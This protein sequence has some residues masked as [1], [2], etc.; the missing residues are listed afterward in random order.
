MKHPH[1]PI[2][3]P[4][5][6]RVT[7]VFAG[8]CVLAASLHGQSEPRQVV[9]D[10]AVAPGTGKRLWTAPL[11]RHQGIKVPAPEAE[12]PVSAEILAR[13]LPVHPGDSS[14]SAHRPFVGT[15]YR[16]AF[17]QGE[18]TPP[19]AERIDPR[20]MD[21]WRGHADGSA[22]TYGFVM[23]QGRITAAKQRRVEALGVTLHEIHTYQSFKAT[24]PFRAIPG[25]L[26]SRDVRWI[27]YA[28]PE[29]K[30]GPFL[31]QRLAA[32]PP[33][34]RI[35]LFVQVFGDDR[36]AAS[37][38][39]VE[40]P[41]SEDGRYGAVTAFLPHGPAQRAFEAL[42][43]RVLVYHPLERIF[44]LEIAAEHCE[45]LARMDLVHCLDLVTSAAVDNDHSAR[46]TGVDHTRELPESDGSS[47]VLG[48]IDSGVWVDHVDLPSQHFVAWNYSKETNTLPTQGTSWHGTFVAGIMLGRGLG[49]PQGRYKGAAPG[50]AGSA[51]TKLFI[52]KA[53]PPKKTAELD[54]A[55]ARMRGGHGTAPHPHIVNCSW[56]SGPGGF[57]TYPMNILVD[58]NA[59]TYGQCMVFSAGNDGGVF[60]D[61]AHK[62]LNHPG[63]SKNAITVGCMTS[64]DISL[65]RA[66]NQKRPQRRS[67]ALPKNHEYAIP[68]ETSDASTPLRM[69]S[70]SFIFSAS[71]TTTVSVHLHAA[72]A[73][74]TAPM[75][76]PLAIAD[77]VLIPKD[78]GTREA[79]FDKPYL[80]SPGAKYFFVIKTGA[81]GT[82]YRWNASLQNTN[83]PA[84]LTIAERPVGGSW[85]NGLDTPIFFLRCSLRAGESAPNSSKGPTH[86]DRFKPDLVAPGVELRSCQDHTTD[87]Y[88]RG[89]TPA[90]SW[91]APHVSGI[92]AGLIDHYPALEYH[93]EGVRALLA[94]TANPHNGTA[95]TGNKGAHGY[96]FRQGMGLPDAHKAN[97]SRDTPQGWVTG[98]EL[99]DLDSSH[100]GA[101]FDVEVP[102]DAERMTTVLTFVEQGASG[103]AMRACLADLDLY[104]EH[105]KLTTRY[106][107]GQYS[108]Q[109]RWDTM[110]AYVNLQSISKLRGKKVRIKVH[111]RVRPAKGRKVRYAVAYCID[112]GGLKPQPSLTITA[113]PMLPGAKAELSG[114]ASLSEGVLTNAV[115]QVL[116][117]GGFEFSD[118][119]MNAQNGLR[120]DPESRVFPFGHLGYWYE[121]RSRRFSWKISKASRGLSRVKIQ[122]R[123]PF[124]QYTR[125]VNVCVDNLVPARPQGLRTLTHSTG[126]WSKNASVIFAWTAVSDQGC[127]GLEGLYYGITQGAPAHVAKGVRLTPSLTSRA[128]PFPSSAADQ[129]LNLFVVDRV[130]LRSPAASLGPFRIDAVAPLIQS[131]QL[132]DG[133]LRTRQ[134][135]LPLTIQRSDA[136]SGVAEY[137]YSMSNGSKWSAWTSIKQAPTVDLSAHGGSRGDGL[138][139][140]SVEVRDKAGNVSPTRRVSVVLDTSA[141]SVNSVSIAGGSATTASLSNPVDLQVSGAPSEYRW[142]MDGSTW[143]PWAD[144]VARF[145]ADLSKHGGSS[146]AG[147]KTVHVMVRDA[148]GNASQVATDSIDYR[149]TPSLKSLNRTKIGNIGAGVLVLTGTRL[150]GA[151]RVDFGKHALSAGTG[152]DWYQGYFKVRSDT[153]ID[154]YAPQALPPG[155]YGLQVHVGRTPSNS[156]ACTVTLVSSR[157]LSC[158]S[159]VD[160]KDKFRVLVA[161]GDQPVDSFSL[162]TASL[163]EVGVSIP[164]FVTLD[165]GGLKTG[166]FH[167]SFF[168]V[169][170]QVAHD[171]VTGVAEWIF[172]A[173]IQGVDVHFQAVVV[174]QARPG[175][176]PFKESS[177]RRIRIR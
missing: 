123:T 160:Y 126:S 120:V 121:S 56:H 114:I 140:C 157:R 22:Q 61:E 125:T 132:G 40:S 73:A 113:P 175:V 159:S 62:S 164:N 173:L 111:A 47:A 96:E 72:N 34:E 23:F 57:G 24:I 135:Q 14:L 5:G 91:A 17:V 165:H 59:Y 28:R 169:P 18:Y 58:S 83:V 76:A 162:L 42:G 63:D 115:V 19:A 45:T 112:R 35:P 6:R 99:N 51:A 106:D 4:V 11:T 107:V 127:A 29:Q 153:R 31:S 109:R 50:A 75:G 102:A 78:R 143:S 39:V 8:I 144:I 136:H 92:A 37:R 2:S 67:W 81:V 118:L 79:V 1:H 141:P 86:D 68:Y 119:V 54:R 105:D 26:A 161:R 177:A 168:L 155:K 98:Y 166:G 139:T 30:L 158:R 95:R 176:L 110:D 133:S 77:N 43:A 128:V 53:L 65:L 12:S 15:P 150:S 71:I 103:L 145:T 122:I 32:C 156:L 101:Y 52:C 84:V 46:A 44:K 130:G 108:S 25:L 16:L 88:A 148:A 134:L 48:I 13:P 138:K 82:V 137:R 154:V 97:G 49:N 85:S 70:V 94:A 152:K 64:T 171:K 174:D 142:S 124:G 167:P 163:S 9:Q 66:F 33:G 147:T 100:G 151:T 38:L 146:T 116:D 131:L 10:P 104:L 36:G 55:V 89:S 172:P 74:G 90:T 87:R 21:V 117:D 41:E 129:Y 149:I 93:P 27:G 60:G 80:T 20:L 7:A 69:E 3:D 170:G